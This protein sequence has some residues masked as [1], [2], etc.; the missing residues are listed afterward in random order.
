MSSKWPYRVEPGD[1]LV[2]RFGALRRVLDCC[3]D[4]D[5][6]TKWVAPQ[7]LRRSW[8]GRGETHINCYD[9]AYR[10]MLPLG[11]PREKP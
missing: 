5:G 11:A 4:K 8:T 1:W 7:I 6:H 10:K 3:Q 9:L 2:T